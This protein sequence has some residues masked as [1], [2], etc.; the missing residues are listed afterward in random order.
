MS[1]T[2]DIHVFRD[3]LLACHEGRRVGVENIRLLV[4]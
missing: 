1:R 2:Q 4:D 3:H